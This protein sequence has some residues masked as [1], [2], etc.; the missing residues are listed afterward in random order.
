MMR[1]TMI[2]PNNALHLTPVNVA[3]I[4]DYNQLY[5]VVGRVAVVV[6]RR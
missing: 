3:K 5:R 4:S 1:Y 2:L 6:G